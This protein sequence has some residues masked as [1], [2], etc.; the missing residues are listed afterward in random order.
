VSSASR[1]DSVR[2]LKKLLDLWDQGMPDIAA[3][4]FK[5]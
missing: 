4:E 2:E 5:G 3:H 1:P